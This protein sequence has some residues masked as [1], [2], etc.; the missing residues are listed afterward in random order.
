MHLLG[1]LDPATA[2]GHDL[3]CTI[4]ISI[5]S[6]QWYSICCTIPDRHQGNSH[7][8]VGHKRCTCSAEKK[9]ALLIAVRSYPSG[10]GAIKHLCHGQN[11]LVADCMLSSVH[12][13]ASFSV[14]F[15]PEPE[16]TL[17]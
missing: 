3:C 6:P 2:G 7:L 9:W 4:T 13:T 15:N 10:V 17:L 11:Q 8:A 5:C 1:W 12:F 16:V 14:S